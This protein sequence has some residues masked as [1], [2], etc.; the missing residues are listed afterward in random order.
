MVRRGAVT[1]EIRGSP[2]LDILRCWP[3]HTR[4]QLPA[5]QH[6]DLVPEKLPGPKTT[7]AGCARFTTMAAG[8]TIA[9]VLK[10]ESNMRIP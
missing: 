7:R 6:V 4:R 1:S 9:E 2:V 3:S 8:F 5:G 10:A